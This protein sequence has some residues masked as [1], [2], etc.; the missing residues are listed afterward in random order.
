MKRHIVLATLLAIVTLAAD[1]ATKIA[2][3]QTF[4]LGESV[5]VLPFFSLTYVQ[6]QGAAWGMFQGAQLLLAA[7]GVVAA[8]LLLCFYR[9]LF[10]AHPR[11]LYVTTLLL[12]GIVGNVIDR[13]RLDYVIDFLHFH[14]ANYHFPCFNVADSAICV[15]VALLF[16]FQ[17]LPEKK[18]HKGE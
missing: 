9:K 10:G 14:W 8:V 18:E 6:N 11:N 12:G 13:L 1:Q 2:V 5:P 3:A 7:F 16:L 15:A 4:A 17:A